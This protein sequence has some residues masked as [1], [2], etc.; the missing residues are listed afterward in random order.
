LFTAKTLKHKGCQNNANVL[1][2]R[3]QVVQTPIVTKSG[4]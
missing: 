1:F 2:A 3:N 4:G